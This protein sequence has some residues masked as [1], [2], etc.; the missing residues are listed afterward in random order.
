[1]S[2]TGSASPVP[3]EPGRRDARFEVVAVDVCQPGTA[4]DENQARADAAYSKLQ[5]MYQWMTDSFSGT[6]EEVTILTSIVQGLAIHDKEVPGQK[7]FA[8]FQFAQGLGSSLQAAKAQ[9]EAYILPNIVIGSKNAATLA[10][11]V[12]PKQH[13]PSSSAF[14]YA[15]E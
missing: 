13:A 9:Y 10:K 6:D 2:S 14:L 4:G 1:M 12:L 3:K 5:K 15:Y 8:E 11:T 7:P